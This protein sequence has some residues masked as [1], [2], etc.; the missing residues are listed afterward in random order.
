MAFGLS[1]ILSIVDGQLGRVKSNAVAASDLNTQLPAGEWNSLI[2]QVDAMQQAI[3][4]TSGATPSS[5]ISVFKAGWLKVVADDTARDAIPA[6]DRPH[7]VV[8]VQNHSGGKSALYVWNVVGG[9]WQDVTDNLHN[10]AS[11]GVL[12]VREVDGFPSALVTTLTMPN[13]TLAAGA[14][15]ELVYTPTSSEIGGVAVNLTGVD[16]GYVL[17]YDAGTP[18]W[19]ASLLGVQDVRIDD[20][21]SQIAGGSASTALGTYLVA[22]LKQIQDDDRDTYIRVEQSADDDTI[23]VFVQGSQRMLFSPDGDVTISTGTTFGFV[24]TGTDSAG[25]THAVGVGQNPFGAAAPSAGFSIANAVSGSTQYEVMARPE[26]ETVQLRAGSITGTREAR[27]TCNS[28]DSLSQAVIAASVGANS[29]T[30]TAGAE[31]TTLSY[32]NIAARVTRLLSGTDHGSGVAPILELSEASENG[33]EVIGIRAPNT[34][35]GSTVYTLPA[36]YPPALDYFLRSATDGGLSWARIK[37]NG[38]VHVPAVNHVLGGLTSVSAVTRWTRDADEVAFTISITATADVNTINTIRISL[39]VASD[40]T[41]D[42]QARAGATPADTTGI[43][44]GCRGES[45]ATNNELLLDIFTSGD[46]GA[47]EITVN[48]HYDVL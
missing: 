32:L 8:F 19:A 46:T 28:I 36:T 11:A 15:G 37:S 14:P 38:G 40:F 2:A 17:R 3:G 23:R 22:A 7:S 18:E 6:D 24:A 9:V 1:S 26:A 47:F 12:T 41:D 35:A 20:S 13:G 43:L 5:I 25:R 29:A 34:L 48:G 30:V 33:T 4:L 27:M 42:T 10:T 39:P 44:V 45:D 16:E 21:A 31:N